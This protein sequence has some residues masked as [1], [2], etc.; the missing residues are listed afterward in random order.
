MDL[1]VHGC[2]QHREHLRA[3]IAASFSNTTPVHCRADNF[4]ILRYSVTTFC[5]VQRSRKLLHF[6]DTQWLT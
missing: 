2:Q 1:I 4:M 3:H 6:F 5:V